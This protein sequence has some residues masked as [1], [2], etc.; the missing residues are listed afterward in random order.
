LSLTALGD[1]PRVA[2]LL[3]SG[4]VKNNRGNLK[5]ALGDFLEAE[6]VEPNNVAVLLRIAEQYSDLIDVTRGSPE[7]EK[8]ARASLRYSQRA[9]EIDPNNAHA[10]LSLSISYGKLT[11]FTDNKTKIEYSKLIRDEALKAIELNPNEDFA[12]HV[13]GRW[14]FGIA[15]INPVLKLLTK[16]VYGSLPKASNQEAVQYLRKATEIAPQRIMHHYELARIY[17][18]LGQRDLA[19]REWRK[20]LDLPALD[21]QDE[22]E[23]RIAAKSLRQ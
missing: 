4:D 15:N 5:G 21:K 3:K 16:M 23:R 11:D 10:H 20:I 13:L 19:R 8:N 1:N 6:K 14:H 17:V 12:Y 7:A 18:A 9:V 2:A 22:E